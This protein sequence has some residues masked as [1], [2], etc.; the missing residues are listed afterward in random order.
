MT[1]DYEDDPG[2]P[3]EDAYTAEEKRTRDKS[4]RVIV[5]LAGVAFLVLCGMVALAV[6][7]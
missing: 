1:L 5:L 2:A 6:H 3:A 4:G 7:G